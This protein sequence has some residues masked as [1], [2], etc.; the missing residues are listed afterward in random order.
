[1]RGV[2]AVGAPRCAGPAMSRA[3]LY[4]VPD[5][6]ELSVACVIL[7]SVN[8][9]VDFSSSFSLQD[10]VAVHLKD[11]VDTADAEALTEEGKFCLRALTELHAF[12]HS[13]T[14]MCFGQELF[15][16]QQAHLVNFPLRRGL[17]PGLRRSG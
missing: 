12:M 15:R 7:C 14:D 16:G 3:L 13:S 6:L 1:M 11:V 9:I 4:P 2:A 10:R 17:R 8:P 5:W